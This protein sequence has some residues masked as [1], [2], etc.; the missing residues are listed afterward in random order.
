MATESV[1]ESVPGYR[2][3]LSQAEILDWKTRP[4]SQ[5]PEW[6]D[7]WLVD[8][9]RTDLSELPAL[10][11]ESEVD[12]VRRRTA[13]VAAGELVVIQAGDC[14]EDPEE[15]EPGALSAKLG[16]L[17]A[18]AGLL[19]VCS[20][21]PVVRVGRIAGQFA[22]PRS[23]PTERHGELELPA[24]RG[25]LV[26]DPAPDPASRRPDPLRMLAAYHASHAAQDFL[27]EQRMDPR[28]PQSS[29]VWTSHEALVLDYEL[30]L[31]R[32]VSSGQRVLASTH[33]P[34]IGER[35]R[36][37]DG[38][39]VALLASVVNPVACKVGPTTTPEELLALCARLDPQREA[40]RLTLISRMGPAATASRLPTLVATVR[41]AGHPV[42]WLCD[43]MHAN[44]IVGP[45]SRKTRKVDTVLAEVSAFLTAVRAAR[46]VPGGLHLETTPTDVTEC[47][48]D[49]GQLEELASARYTTLCDPRLNP[50]QA[51]AVVG[52]WR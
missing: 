19:R 7:D 28:L 12:T 36:D 50:Q 48:R 25:P 15:C 2:T 47:V 42:S 11:T 9:I 46:G 35:T 33:W 21:K 37:P 3:S 34:W 43:P 41:A 14:A 16:L 4:A 49:E 29:E 38:A 23:K 44:T 32:R 13:R 51:L 20:G 24:Y 30:P 6:G 52:A 40:G 45:G 22:K 18:L 26:N 17:E 10:T 39:H 1:Q 27:R 5:Q 8:K 31:V